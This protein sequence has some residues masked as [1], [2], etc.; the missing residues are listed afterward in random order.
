MGSK[1]AR[2]ILRDAISETPVIVRVCCEGYDHIARFNVTRLFELS[3]KLRIEY[4]LRCLRP[5]TAN[6]GYENEIAGSRD[7]QAS[8]LRDNPR[9][10]VFRNNLV[11]IPFWHRERCQN[12][13][14]RGIE[15]GRDLGVCSSFNNVEAD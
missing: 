14:M 12:G 15:Q 10:L 6:H 1:I 8:I 9:R 13:T 2:Q 4:L 5:R 7:P 11:A 3:T